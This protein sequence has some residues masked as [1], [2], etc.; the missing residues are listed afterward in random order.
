M[1]VEDP[2]CKH[3]ISSAPYDNWKKKYGGI[4]HQW[5]TEK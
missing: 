4:E 5:N 2:S 1:K 3:A